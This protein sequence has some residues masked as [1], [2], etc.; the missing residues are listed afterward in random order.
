MG[1]NGKEDDRLVPS[2]KDTRREL[3]PS[4]RA[5]LSGYNSRLSEG[6]VKPPLFRTSTFEFAS[7]EEGR[8]FFQRAYHLPGDDGQEPGLI[9]SRL[10]NP[11]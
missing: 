4:T 9:Y 10:N 5:I 11:N 1:C 7:A 3:H 8:Q 6:A 2:Y